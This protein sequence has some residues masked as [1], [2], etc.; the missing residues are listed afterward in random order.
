MATNARPTAKDVAERLLILRCLVGHAMTTPPRGMLE[1]MR[2]AATAERWEEFSKDAEQRREQFCQM[3]RGA[4]LWEKASP[5]EQEFMSVSGLN[6]TPQQHI[7]ASW[8]LEA[9]QVIAWA[10]GFLESIPPYDT[11][12]K[13][14]LIMGIGPAT[15]VLELA[16]LRP[17]PDIDKQRN[18]AELWHWRSRTRQLIDSGRPFPA[19]DDLKAKGFSSYDD[20]VRFTAARAAQA[21]YIPSPIDNDFPV[22]GKAYRDLSSQEWSQLRSLSKERHFA[23]NWMCGYAPGNRWDET[24]TG[25]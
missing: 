6:I 4:G 2:G 23:L 14:D 24:P 5:K 9:A 7:D 15:E 8:R 1:G 19:S 21:G 20:I 10:L 25:T 16:R 12:A 18:L 13:Q 22:M 11:K 17:Q 3:L